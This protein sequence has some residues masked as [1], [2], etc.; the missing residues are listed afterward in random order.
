MFFGRKKWPS[1]SKNS[2]SQSRQRSLRTLALSSQRNT[3]LVHIRT[4]FDRMNNMV[5]DLYYDAYSAGHLRFFCG[6]TKQKNNKKKGRKKA[7]KK[8]KKKKEK[9]ERKKKK[10]KK[11]ENNLTF[12]ACSSTELYSSVF[13]MVISTIDL[14]H[15]LRVRVTWSAESKPCWIH[16]PPAR[17]Y[18]CHNE[19]VKVLEKFRL[20][21]LI[22]SC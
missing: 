1:K 14:P 4:A 17:F 16:F 18:T 22:Q 5:I 13:T 21:N 6:K 7:K 19:V 20:I 11:K 15:R 9:K 10:K 12:L 8:K 2:R 3:C